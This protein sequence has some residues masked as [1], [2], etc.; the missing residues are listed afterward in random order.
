MALDKVTFGSDDI[1]N[2]LAKMDDKKLDSLAFGAIQLDASGKIM[3]YNAAE[4]SITGRDPKSVI[5]KNFFTDVAPC[6]QSKE[7]QG[8]F[9]EGVKNND[10]NT[11]FEYIFDYKMKPTKVKV[12]M[13]KALTGDSYWIFVKRL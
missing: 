9:K 6:T 1:E 10:L 2:S 3:Q 13:K 7:F 4:G 11:M 8:R 5:G 12:H